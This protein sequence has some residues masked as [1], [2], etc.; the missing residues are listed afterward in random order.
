M[1]Q[2]Y[3][4]ARSLESAIHPLSL[5]ADSRAC[6]QAT[7][8]APWA[9]SAGFAVRPSPEWRAFARFHSHCG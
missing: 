6:C 1:L 9:D 3:L 4:Y 8:V 7:G 2:Q 5:L